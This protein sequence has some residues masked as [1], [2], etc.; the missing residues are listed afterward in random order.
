MLASSGYAVFTTERMTQRFKCLCLCLFLSRQCVPVANTGKLVPRSAFALTM[1]PATPLTALAN[2]SQAGLETTVHRVRT[3]SLLFISPTVCV[4]SYNSFLS[5]CLSWTSHV[6]V[7]YKSRPRP[8]FSAKYP[9]STAD[10]D[11]QFLQ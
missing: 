5:I 9:T 3:N 2:A 11:Q 7:P 8:F 1:A 4:L 10:G 6:I